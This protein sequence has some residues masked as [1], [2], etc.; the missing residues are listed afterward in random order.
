VRINDLEKFSSEYKLYTCEVSFAKPRW[1]SKECVVNLSGFGA[2]EQR[3]ID[4][5]LGPIPP[6]KFKEAKVRLARMLELDDAAGPA[7]AAHE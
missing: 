3:R 5:R 6:S 4:R 7:A 1:L 2:I